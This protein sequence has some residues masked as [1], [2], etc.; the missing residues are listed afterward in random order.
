[1]NEIL[2]VPDSRMSGLEAIMWHL[3]RDP[4]LSVAFANVT[5][6]D[7]QP[8]MARLRQRLSSATWE[9]PRLRQ[10]VVERWPRIAPPLWRE[11]PEFNIDNH[12]LEETLP[13]AANSVRD[14]HRRI[15]EI[16]AVPLDAERPQ[17]QFTVIGGFEGGKAA[18]LQ[19]LHH[20]ITD[21]EGGLKMSLQFV[22]FERDP[23]NSD[24]GRGD[25]NSD[26]Q[27]RRQRREPSLISDTFKGVG[28]QARHFSD[29]ASSAFSGIRDRV[30]NSGDLTAMGQDL[31][32][33]ARSLR[34][35]AVAVEHKSSDLWANRSTGR[36]F[37]T[38]DVNL[39]VVLDRA[40]DLDVTV[41]DIFVSAVVDAAAQYHAEFDN[42]LSELHASVPVSTRDGQSGANHFSPTLVTIRADQSGPLERLRAVNAELTKVKSDR[43]LG[44]IE[45]MADTLNLL[46]IP[47]VVS[48]GKWVTSHVDVAVSNIKAS[49]FELFIGGAKMESNHPVGP[50]A[51]AA[52]N[53]TLMSYCGTLNI[54]INVDTAAISDA[55]S[56]RDHLAAA[57]A[58][59]GCD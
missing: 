57:F 17:W 25:R 44:F 20:S 29:L 4:L 40:H 8:D 35:Q 6:L 22:D 42:E 55:E 53:V 18:M 39:K 9:V 15:S 43:T 59:L 1:M 28:Y 36:E 3:E 47:I 10:R 23:A 45:P 58:R 19:R 56:F 30:T 2:E 52:V 48:A 7:Q 33:M 37:A 50:L 41:N 32:E 14:L 46:P 24:D 31:L 13:A 54:G 34:R 5:I 12:L 51:G 38:L 26:R 21:G 16:C 11:D 49:P 27:E